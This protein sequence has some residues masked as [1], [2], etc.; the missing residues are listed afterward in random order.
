LRAQRLLSLVLSL[1]FVAVFATGCS[2]SPVADDLGQREANEIVS[3]LR[4]HGI[5]A[6]TEKERGSRGHYS[7]LVPYGRFGEAASILTELGLPQ[8]RRAS[9]TDLVAQSGILPSSREV[10]ALRLDR[11]VAAELEDLLK[12]HLAIASASVVVRYHAIEG[13]GAPSV[14]VVVQRRPGVP[15]Q[16]SEIRDMVARSI[17]GIKPDAIV[18][19]MS[20]QPAAVSLASATKGTKPLISFLGFWQVPEDQY[21]SLAFTLITFLLLVAIMAGLAGYIYGQYALSRE[22]IPDA[23]EALEAGP[24]APRLQAP[25]ES[26]E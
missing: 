2:T 25:E 12:G 14:S 1:V 11:A 10:E 13:N 8:D 17:P 9:F 21:N 26:Q 15:L 6:R 18:L 5:E 16:A 4:E 7:V 22:E 19:S 24:Q 3:V 20:E 23:Y